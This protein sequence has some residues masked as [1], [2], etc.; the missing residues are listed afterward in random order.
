M[1]ITQGGSSAAPRARSSTSKSFFDTGLQHRQT[2]MHPISTA[3]EGVVVVVVERTAATAAGGWM[4]GN[5]G[6]S[7]I[8][9]LV[10]LRL[11]KKH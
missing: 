11:T 2:A 3:A 6:V 8:A 9:T 1:A 4:E 5:T 7:S 10:I